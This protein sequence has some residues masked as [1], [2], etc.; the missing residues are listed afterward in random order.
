MKDKI[1]VLNEQIKQY[2][3]L[4]NLKDTLVVAQSTADDVTRAA[5]QKSEIIIE[6]A[7]LSAKR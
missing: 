1:L 7:E 4:E 3:N 6:E 2:N 5:R